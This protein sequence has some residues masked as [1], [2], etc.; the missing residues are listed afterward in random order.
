MHSFM[1]PIW[2]GRIYTLLLERLCPG[3]FIGRHVLHTIES[4]TV[5]G[6]SK[7]RRVQKGL[8]LPNPGELWGFIYLF[9]CTIN[10][11]STI[12]VRKAF[13]TNSNLTKPFNCQT[14]RT[15]GGYVPPLGLRLLGDLGMMMG[16]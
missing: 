7:H 10:L 11:P 9:D 12:H 8:C 1:N 2:R 4:K 16:W 14:A 5:V 6:H 3:L 15:G 13:N